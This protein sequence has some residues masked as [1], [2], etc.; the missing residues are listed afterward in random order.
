MKR[1][2]AEKLV[3]YTI[4]QMGYSLRNEHVQDVFENAVEA[5]EILT[6]KEVVR[7]IEESL[8]VIPSHLLQGDV[9]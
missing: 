6:R 3:K 8:E 9:L 5:A 1:T 2:T 7:L 4:E